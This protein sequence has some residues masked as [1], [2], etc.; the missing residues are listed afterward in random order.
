MTQNIKEMVTDTVIT[1][2]VGDYPAVETR[3]E[4]DMAMLTQ[5]DEDPFFLT[6]KISEV[7]ATS[8]NGLMHDDTLGKALAKQINEYA[9][10]GIAGHLREEDRSTEFPMPAVYWLGALC[11]NGQTWAKGYIP[12]TATQVREHYRIQKATG[13]KAATSIYG[14]GTKEL[15]D[16]KNKTWRLKEFKL[17]QLDLAPFERAALPL[18]GRFTVTAQMDTEP[19]KDEI[20]DKEQVVAELK[21]EDVKSLP[22][23]VV[24]AIIAQ[25]QAGQGEQ[26][27]VK[28]LQSEVDKGKERIA[29]LEAQL[30]TVRVAEFNKSLDDL[31]SETVKI[32]AKTEE[33]QKRVASLRSLVRRYVVA[34]LAG[35]TNLDEA[36][37]VVKEYTGT[38]EY[39]LLAGAIVSELTGPRAFVGAQNQGGL[40]TSDEA[41]AAARSKFGL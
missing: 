7:G 12:K 31:V 13:G 36:E 28:E 21:A 5:G 1:E 35:K 23:V 30:E 8:N 18:D 41:V 14:P 33:G 6:L 11:Q 32:E 39:K 2:F 4:V 9:A 27:R 17:E 22:S 20:M 40:D 24:E 10:H 3:P 19:V 34:E 15:V 29:E 37:K 16:K 26:E 38:E 25:Y